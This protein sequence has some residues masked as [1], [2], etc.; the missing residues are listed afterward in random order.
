MTKLKK[1]Q[2]MS[3][4]DALALTPDDLPDGAY[5]AMA[6]EMAGL[7]YGDGFDEIAADVD[8]D[9]VYYVGDDV[10]LEVP[11]EPKV[12]RCKKCKRRFGSDQ[13]ARQHHRDVHSHKAKGKLNQMG[14]GGRGKHHVRK[15]RQDDEF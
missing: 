4:K 8:E 7:E 15:V 6:H 13:A 3:F 11:P 9:G 10:D 5:F 12:H 1:G 2:R 14:D